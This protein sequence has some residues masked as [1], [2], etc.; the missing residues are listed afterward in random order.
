MEQR[1]MPPPRAGALLRKGSGKLLWDWSTLEGGH[2]FMDFCKHR[3][4]LPGPPMQGHGMPLGWGREGRAEQSW[5][6]L[7]QLS[8]LLWSGAGRRLQSQQPA[9]TRRVRAESKEGVATPGSVE[10]P[11]LSQCL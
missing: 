10:E 7:E 6:F 4:N 9:L 1:N 8:P 5:G 3:K 11:H 2:R